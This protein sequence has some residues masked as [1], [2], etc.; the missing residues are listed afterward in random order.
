MIIANS[1]MLPLREDL[2][3]ITSRS[4]AAYR[5]RKQAL[6]EPP[7]MAAVTFA[8]TTGRASTA[9]PDYTTTE[10]IKLYNKATNEMEPPYDLSDEGLYAFLHQVSHQA[11]QM[12]WGTIFNVPVTIVGVDLTHDILSQHGMLNLAQVRAHVLTYQGLDGRAAHNSQQMYTFL[13][14]CLDDQACMRMSMQEEQ[15]KITVGSTS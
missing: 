4:Q 2:Y 5:A 9:T 3:T 13:Y 12:N 8:L 14:E 10:G 11:N 7:N 1:L 15:Y 6:I